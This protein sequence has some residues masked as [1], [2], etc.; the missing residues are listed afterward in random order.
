M[1]TVPQ[2]LDRSL[3]A[4]NFIIKRFETVKVSALLMKR[5]PVTWITSSQEIR[6]MPEYLKPTS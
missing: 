4:N 3:A 5:L 1:L 6:W 2:A